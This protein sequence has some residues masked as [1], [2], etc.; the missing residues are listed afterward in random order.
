[1]KKIIN[2]NKIFFIISLLLSIFIFIIGIMILK[3]PIILYYKNFIKILAYLWILL[4]LIDLINIKKNIDKYKSIKKY[5][6]IWDFCYKDRTPYRL[7]EFIFDL[8]IIFLEIFKMIKNP[9]KLIWFIT[10]IFL[11][12]IYSIIFIIVSSIFTMIILWTILLYL[13][14]K[15]KITIYV[16]DSNLVT[17]FKSLFEFIFIDNPFKQSFSIVYILISRK[18]Q[19][20]FKKIIEN[21]MF[22][23]IIGKSKF[24]LNMIIILYLL[25]L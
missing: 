8:D 11:C 12:I 14:F 1:M 21:L 15:K 5:C 16:E 10:S 13:L 17:D 7:K 23:Q 6:S 24:C 22:S 4:N 3:N 9:L 19:T 18:K 25:E 20:N 2:S